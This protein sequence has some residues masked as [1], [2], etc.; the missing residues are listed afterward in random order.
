MW[1]AVRQIYKLAYILPAI[2]V[3]VVL[4]AYISWGRSGGGGD[5]GCQS[6]LK[7]VV[8]SHREYKVSLREDCRCWWHLFSVSQIG[9][10]AVGSQ[11]LSHAGNCD[12]AY[13]DN[14]IPQTRHKL[15]P[16][17]GTHHLLQSAHKVNT[18]NALKIIY[19]IKTYRVC[20]FHTKHLLTFAEASAVTKLWPMLY[21]QRELTVQLRLPWGN[22]H[23]GS[24]IQHHRHIL[25]F[26]CFK[27]KCFITWAVY[28]WWARV[29]PCR[30]SVVQF[31]LCLLCSDC[32]SG[33][34]TCQTLLCAESCTL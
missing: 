25:C 2:S 11:L 27:F 24:R 30:P 20:V 28:T 22:Q 9:L 10:F 16:S 19:T 7:F 15:Q 4:E 31:I 21:K 33:Y 18:Q 13:S 5:L 12:A 8:H 32:A 26:R 23:V 6:G 3:C 17:A 1:N 14:Y 29:K 34:C